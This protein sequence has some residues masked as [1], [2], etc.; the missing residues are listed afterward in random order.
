MCCVYKW[1]H[2]N[3][4]WIPF[5]SLHR[6][7]NVLLDCSNR[8]AKYI[9]FKSHP[10]FS[11]WSSVDGYSNQVHCHDH[12]VAALTIYMKKN[13]FCCIF[14][15]NCRTNNDWKKIS[16]PKWIKS[17]LKVFFFHSV[18]LKILCQHVLN[19]QKM[20]IF[21]SV[22][23]FNVFQFTLSSIFLFRAYLKRIK[24]NT[25]L[26]RVFE[27]WQSDWRWKIMLNQ[28]KFIFS[29]TNWEKKNLYI[30]R[31]LPILHKSCE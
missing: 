1:Q 27:M 15:M 9:N 13:F 22:F 2:L 17:N 23:L 20:S 6:V 21:F 11:D 14:T 4:Y 18:C 7:P 25:S 19:W 26:W 30:L 8:W 24:F 10:C 5:A 12:P 31:T 28:H 3:L 16:L 29:A